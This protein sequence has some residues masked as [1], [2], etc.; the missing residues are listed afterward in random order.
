MIPPFTTPYSKHIIKK[1]PKTHK[2]KKNIKTHDE[3]KISFFFNIKINLKLISNTI[4][5]YKI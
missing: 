4:Y 1:N 5:I 3:K 2:R